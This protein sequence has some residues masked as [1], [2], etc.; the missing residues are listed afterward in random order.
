M[1]NVKLAGKTPEIT[2]KPKSKIMIYGRAG[3]G[4]TWVSLEFP[5][6]YYIDTEGGAAQNHYKEKLRTSGGAYY[7]PEDGALSFQSVLEQV[8]A[9][10][11]TKHPYKTLVIDSIS[12]SFNNEV[13]EEAERLGDKNTFGTD[14]KPAIAMMR[15]IVKWLQKIDMNVILIAHEKPLWGNINGERQ[16]IGVIFDCWDKL[17]YE[18]DLVLNIL[19]RGPSRKAIVKKSRLSEFKD[20]EIFDWGYNQFSEIYGKETI[21]G[22]VKEMVLASEEQLKKF[23]SLLESWKEPDGWRTNVLK[24]ANAESFEEIEEEK[25]I[26]L[27]EYI[28]TKLTKDDQK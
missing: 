23:Y 19:K 18:L 5:S 24:H 14:K 7:G 10:A 16:E 25:V 2:K 27:I 26:K 8:Q 17:E 13:S 4:K 22:E 20:G 1:K 28:R 12:K 11:T 6:V 15:R 3:V 21:E 9:L